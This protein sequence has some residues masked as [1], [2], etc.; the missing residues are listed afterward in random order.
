MVPAGL[1]PL[2]KV[3]QILPKRS[4]RPK[5]LSW[6]AVVDIDNIQQHEWPI[7]RELALP[8]RFNYTDLSV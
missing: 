3:N 8:L 5:A 7:C 6:F 2:Q 4:E 1:S